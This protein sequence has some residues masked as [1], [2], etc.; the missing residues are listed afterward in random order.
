MKALEA[1]AGADVLD[2]LAE[3]VDR[4][5]VQ[6]ST[7]TSKRFDVMDS[8][9][10]FAARQLTDD[11]A[12]LLADRHS[13]FF[14]EVGS[15]AE[16]GLVGDRAAWWQDSL[17][18]DHENYQAVL[19]RLVD[20]GDAARGLDL[21]GGSW[22]Y[23]RAAGRL[24]EAKLWLDRLSSLPGAAEPTLHRARGLMARGAVE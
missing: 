12:A 2:D 3:L 5:L 14:V 11:E 9:S 18:D 16:P 15:A 13:A 8:V 6:A 10:G 24:D 1:V 23:Y 7:A 20:A 21:I 17:G 19:G 4:G 22:R